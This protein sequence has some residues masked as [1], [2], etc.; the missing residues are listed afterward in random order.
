MIKPLMRF[1][2]AFYFA[3]ALLLALIAGAL[4]ILATGADPLVA[5]TAGV[6]AA[7][8]TIYRVLNTLSNATVLI[9]TGLACSVAFRVGVWNIGVE[10]QLYLG[11]FAAALAGL[12]NGLPS[13]IHLP[14]TLLVAVL[15][16]LV[17]AAIPGI[18]RTARGTNEI[19]VTLMM[20]YLAVM[21]TSYFVNYPFK[22]PGT[23]WPETLPVH[24]SAQLAYLYPLTH[25][26]ASFFVALG[27]MLVVLFIFRRTRL[28]YQWR[29]VGLNERA[30]ALGGIHV[31]S[32]ML[33]AMLV[34]GALGGLAGGL[35][36]VGMRYRFM[37]GFSPGYGMSGILIALIA[38]N[39]PVQ[40]AVVALIFAF[41]K[42]GATG[43][44]LATN[45]PAELSEILQTLIVLFLAV[46]TSFA[47]VFRDLTKKRPARG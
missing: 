42:S 16:G 19:V 8:G 36:V 12:M 34:S 6:R 21:L 3:L 10:G 5:Y 25:F 13:G 23:S 14:L 18:L 31:R 45:V 4:I 9:L 1:Q 33:L 43:M 41:L 30:S 39:D 47:G 44:E 15:A 7:A 38:R 35:E 22:A 27:V 32:T 46:Q 40:V 2:N 17:W 20:N 26:S 11:G 28:G 24:T 37:D 29:M